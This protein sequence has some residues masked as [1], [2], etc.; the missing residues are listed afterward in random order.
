MTAALSPGD[1]VAA[2][3]SLEQAL[4]APPGAAPT[5]IGETCTHTLTLNAVEIADGARRLLDLNP[6]H[7]DAIA[8]R[9]AGYPGVVASG[10]HTGALLLGIT[11]THFTGAAPDGTPRAMLGLGYELRFRSVLHA[12]EALTLRWTV[13]SS[14]WKSSLRGYVTEAEGEARTPRAL[15]LSATCRFL[16]RRG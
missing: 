7:H 10:A 6:L 5:E 3:G 11:A 15:V 2:V 4:G 14:T 12:G 8:A 13:T 9:A 1:G 16:L